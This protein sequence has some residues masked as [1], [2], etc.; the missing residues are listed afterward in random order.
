M[1]RRR[2][3]RSAGSDSLPDDEWTHEPKVHLYNLEHPGKPLYL[4][5]YLAFMLDQSYVA[6]TYGGGQ[7]LF[8]VV[9][10]GRLLRRG[11]WAIEGNPIRP[12]GRTA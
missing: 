1:K 6:A 12:P 10:R 5:T 7:Y 8:I 9:Y 2:R 3:K 4:G 11:V